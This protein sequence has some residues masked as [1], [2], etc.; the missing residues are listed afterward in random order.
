MSLDNPAVYQEGDVVV[1]RASA[2]GGCLRALA[3]ARQGYTPIPPPPAMQ[4]VYAAG[5]E[6][7][8]QVWAKGM[9]T[10]R[11]Q[12][13][14]VLPISDTIQIAGHL[15]AWEPARVVEVKSQSADM[16]GPIRL[17]PLWE[18]YQWQFSV[19]MLATGSP[20]RL[21]RVLR[22]GDGNVSE[23][24]EELFD[25]P[26]RTLTE[27][28]SRVLTVETMA[29]RDLGGVPCD[30]VEFPCP[31]FYTHM[32]GQGAAPGEREFVDD[33]AAV[34]LAE[35]YVQAR[36]QMRVAKGRVEVSR[37]ALLAWMGD[38]G[39]VG[40]PDGWK[41][42]KYRVDPHHVEYDASGYDGLRVTQPR[43]KGERTED[44]DVR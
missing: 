20:L 32:D 24:A 13:H 12:E 42:S 18:R 5:H 22:D 2:L 7:E 40:L 8:R 35:Q 28:R 16:F 14:V 4:R 30:R 10:G 34:R 31:Y 15:D 26:P 3:L 27:V 1:Y 43:D 19:Y 41:L 17:S 21:L 25:T 33:Q 37:A 29:R 36:D 11:A 44:R 6:A 23:S 38:R 39:K 9:V